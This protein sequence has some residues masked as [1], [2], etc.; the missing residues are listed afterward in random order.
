MP[1]WFCLG[2]ALC[3]GTLVLC[4]IESLIRDL[5]KLSQSNRTEDVPLNASINLPA[6][7]PTFRRL[8]TFHMSLRFVSSSSECPS[9]KHHFSI[10]TMT[11][12][13]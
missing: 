8:D 10:T 4:S 2:H 6:L 9:L 12:Q 13:V 11:T 5:V 3:L 1:A 7:T